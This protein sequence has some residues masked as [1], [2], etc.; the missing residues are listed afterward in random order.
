MQKQ[1]AI[2]FRPYQFGESALA[3]SRQVWLAGLG[4]TVVTRDWV[5]SEAGHVFKTL[6]KEGTVVESR[7]IRFFGDQFETSLARANT[8]WKQTRRTVETTVKQAATSV[9]DYAQQALP[10]SLPKI[11]LPKILV[12]ASPKQSLPAKR[13]KKVVKART[14]KAAT[15]TKR[16]ARRTT[17][18]A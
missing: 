14:A 17:K 13:A 3:A 8:V 4:A 11:E 10:K 2:N 12:A 16:T 18:R 9:V 15:K 6:V 7:A 5:Q 1:A